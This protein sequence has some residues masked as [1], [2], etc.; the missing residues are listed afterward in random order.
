MTGPPNLAPAQGHIVWVCR[1]RVQLYERINVRVL[2]MIK[3]GWIDECNALIGTK[4][5]DFIR[6]KKLIGYAEL[7]DY[8]YGTIGA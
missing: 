1:D 5:E 4:W 3:Q 2:A 6:R 7:L 8:L